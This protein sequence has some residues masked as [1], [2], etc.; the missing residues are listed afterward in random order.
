MESN[1]R[2]EW[3]P[4]DMDDEAELGLDDAEFGIEEPAIELVDTSNP[5]SEG[6]IGDVVDQV[7]E[8]N[9]SNEELEA[10]FNAMNSS[11]SEQAIITRELA[12]EEDGTSPAIPDANELEAELPVE[13]SPESEYYR[14]QEKLPEL[15]P[16]Q[17]PRPSW[18]QSPD[19]IQPSSPEAR[20][21]LRIELPKASPRRLIE[22]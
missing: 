15:E 9:S 7:G 16:G 17:A 13:N 22:E 8:E 6:G 1:E 2:R 5:P 3:L 18:P 14:R 21:V 12:D 19:G 11:D 10:T 4:G 20:E